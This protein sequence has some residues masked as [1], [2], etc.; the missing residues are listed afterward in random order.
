M[1]K[2]K[3][4]ER[5]ERGKGYVTYDETRKRWRATIRLPN[6][7]T[8]T[9]YFGSADQAEA[10]Q[11]EQNEELSNPKPE[12]PPPLPTIREALGDYLAVRAYLRQSTLTNYRIHGRRIN[13]AVGHLPADKC[14]AD[15]VERF[16]RKN[17][18][19]LSGDVADQVL[20][21]LSGVYLRLIALKLVTFNPVA[22]Y[23]EITPVRARAGRATRVG[24]ILDVGICRMVLRKLEGD[25]YYAPIVWMAVLGLRAGELRG[26]RWVN[27]RDG[28]AWIVEQRTIHDRHEGA[29]L[30]TED[31]IGEGRDLPVPSF[32][33][34]M[35][36]RGNDSDLMFPNKDGGSIDE[37]TLRWHLNKAIKA[38]RVPHF[39][40]HDLRHTAGSHVLRL[41]CPERYV[42]AF[43]G[44]SVKRKSELILFVQTAQYAKPDADTLRPWVEEWAAALLGD[45][46]DKRRKTV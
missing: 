44:H 11:R 29:P 32:L 41:G 42:A 27:V 28:V 46:V 13:A 38:A 17:R 39:R 43:L 33:L 30:K 19:T 6:G 40:V 12:P 25:P 45:Q 24:K 9:K 18:E 20:M 5:G 26:L 2:R 22:A 15:E 14:G 34:A 7:G 35:V 23:R 1:A 21:L 8:R 3:R 16:D 31:T 36:E 4:R 37:G 10:W